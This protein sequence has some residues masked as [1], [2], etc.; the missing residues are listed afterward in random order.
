MSRSWVWVLALYC[1]SV[2]VAAQ[3]PELAS[4]S[5]VV[6]QRG[7]GIPIARALVR[8][9]GGVA[10]TLTDDAGRFHLSDL[11]AGT[12]A[13]RIQRVGYVPLEFEIDL[14]A[15][16]AV[17]LQPGELLL[18]A[19]AVTI[20]SVVVVASGER[21]IPALVDVGFYDRRK[22]T[23]GSFMVHDQ[24]VKRHAQYFTDVLRTIPGVSIVPN[25]NY[26]R[27]ARPPRRGAAAGVAGRSK[28]VID[29]RKQLVKMRGCETVAL[30]LDG[31]YVGSADEIDIDGFLNVRDIE[32]IEAYRGAAEMPAR[33]MTAAI[34]C[35]AVVVWTTPPGE[36]H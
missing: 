23:P 8:E 16:E 13:F 26:M 7:A 27:P 6:R 11:A 32:A 4:L 1:T 5:G 34:A 35:G 33:F 18:N 28:M 24:V 9:M 19:I 36:L 25:S 3:E 29:T 22:L 20:D 17:E 21:L 30:W 14:S 31:L 15:G 12:H 2:E 10:L